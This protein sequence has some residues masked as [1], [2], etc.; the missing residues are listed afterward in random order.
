MEIE[1]KFNL[2]RTREKAIEK[3]KTKQFDHNKKMRI[4][5]NTTIGNIN[6]LDYNTIRT[7]IKI[8]TQQVLLQSRNEQQL[9][10]KLKEKG[11]DLLINSAGNGYNFNYMK[12]SFKASEVSRD[13]SFANIQK[14]LKENSQVKEKTNLNEPSKVNQY[15]EMLNLKQREQMEQQEL[16]KPHFEEQKAKE[17]A[18][19]KSIEESNIERIARL[20][21][22]NEQ[23]QLDEQKE[24]K[25]AL[26]QD[27]S[28]G[29]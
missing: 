8:S 5:R 6:Q 28:Y 27:I 20:K 23:R 29:I 2:T 1:A 3:T 4:E 15:I 12:T 16:N 14:Q 17:S 25:N 19:D 22:E 26:N 10:D 24:N 13:L 21:I 9:K 7:F 11:I 18:I